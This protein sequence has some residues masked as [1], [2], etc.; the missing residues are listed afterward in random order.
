MKVIESDQAKILNASLD[1]RDNIVCT[2][3]EIE[4]HLLP[5]TNDL[6]GGVYQLYHKLMQST[7]PEWKLLRQNSFHEFRYCIYLKDVFI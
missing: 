4:P 7:S 5:D 2:L 3:G 1:V 6:G